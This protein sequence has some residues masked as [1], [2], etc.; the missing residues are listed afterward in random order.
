[1]KRVFYS[2]LVAAILAVMVAGC[3]GS[4]SGLGNTNAQVRINNAPERWEYK[5]V[6]ISIYPQYDSQGMP[7]YSISESLF[8][9]LGKDGWEFVG[10]SSIGNGYSSGQI[11]KRRLP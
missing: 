2:V 1:M 4:G 11:F 8:N 6:D 9:E 7:S 5:I 10:F 3:V